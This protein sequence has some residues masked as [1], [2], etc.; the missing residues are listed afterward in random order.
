MPGSASRNGD[1]REGPGF[2]LLLRIQGRT[3]TGAAPEAGDRFTGASHAL[4]GRLVTK[5]RA[6]YHRV[7]RTRSERNLTGKLCDA[8]LNADAGAILAAGF[9]CDLPVDAASVR[10]R[11][12]ERLPGRSAS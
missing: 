5:L 11:L 4:E 6:L 12:I 1:R 7:T 2:P 3:A 8:R 10:S 9:R